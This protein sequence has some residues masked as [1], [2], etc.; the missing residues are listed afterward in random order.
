MEIMVIKVTLDLKVLKVTKV[1][2]ELKVTLEL[3]AFKETKVMLL[4][5]PKEN[6]EFQ[7]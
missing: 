4:K 1:F 2:K 6:K 3:K 7:V 5:A